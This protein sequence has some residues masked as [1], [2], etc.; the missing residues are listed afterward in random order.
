MMYVIHPPHPEIADVIKLAAEAAKA[1]SMARAS[2]Y[3]CEAMV[4]GNAARLLRASYQ[5]RLEMVVRQS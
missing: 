5:A 3:P 4:Y 1:T 2:S